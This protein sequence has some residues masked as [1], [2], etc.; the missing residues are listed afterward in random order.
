MKLMLIV[1]LI[2]G[3][4]IPI[5]VQAE[6]EEEK[7]KVDSKA[8]VLLES[9]TGAVL[10][11]KNGNK[12]MYPASLTK[13]A[14][15]IYAI[16]KGNI[17]DIVTVSKKAV[18]VEGTKVYLE[19]GE[20][21]TV[22]HLLD[23]MLINSGNDAAMAVAEYLDGSQE[24]FEENFNKYLQENI[25]LTSTHFTNPHGLFDKNHYTTAND[26]AKITQYALKNDAFRV[27]FGTKQLE[28][29]GESWNTTLY[30]HHL[31]LKGELPNHDIIGGKTGFVNESKQTLATAAKNKDMGLIA[32]VLKGNVKKEIYEDTS[33]LLEYGFTQFQ[34]KQIEKGHLYFNDGKTYQTI[35]NEMITTPK[36]DSKSSV[37]SEGIL[38]IKAE[39]N[40]IIQNISL[41]E[42][43]KQVL[44]TESTDSDTTENVHNHKSK[45]TISILFVAAGI[46]ILFVWIKMRKR[47]NR[48]FS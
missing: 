45:F 9:N 14:T 2:L 20:K 38:Q 18:D 36:T 12:K 48:L 10:Y 33:N 23:G 13:I 11:E 17:N 8:A 25:H 30:T 44:T 6:Q 4:F 26:M 7:V 40:R 28:W 42:L 35:K 37:T 16:E 31:M 43:E 15:S 21:V 29:H 3:M 46:S 27:I 24:Q 1:C 32:I 41:Q 19:Q 47:Y 22:K 34:L 5:H 39:D